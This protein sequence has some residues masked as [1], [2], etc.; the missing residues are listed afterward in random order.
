MAT[1]AQEKVKWMSREARRFMA[2]PDWFETVDYES[3]VADL[4]LCHPSDAS[5]DQLTTLGSEVRVL[6]LANP[7]LVEGAE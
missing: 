5:D 3:D 2:S 7:S 4:L 1:T 6:L